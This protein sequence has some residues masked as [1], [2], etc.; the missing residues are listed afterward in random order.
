MNSGFGLGSVFAATVLV[1][2][3][4]A[5]TTT[6][7]SLAARQSHAMASAGGRVF[8][9]GGLGV[10]PLQSSQPV[11]RDVH[12]GTFGVGTAGWARDPSM[13]RTLRDHAAAGLTISGQSVFFVFGGISAAGVPTS[14]TTKHTGRTPDDIIT[15]FDP[16]P[17]FGHAMVRV[18]GQNGQP[19]WILMF[20]GFGS[21]RLND[22]W[23]FDPS[24]P[25]WT[26]LLPNAP[27]AGL[28][29][30]RFQHSMAYHETS[31]RIYVFGGN[32]GIA[33]AG[34]WELDPNA[35]PPAWSHIP[36]TGAAPSA[37]NSAAMAYFPVNNT[38]EVDSQIE[39]NMVLVL[40]TAK[41][42]LLGDGQAH[43]PN[44]HRRT[45]GCN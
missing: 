15:A 37:R 32:I 18:P 9:A 22:V 41:C 31:N 29:T 33:D 7:E 11:L 13:P 28:P 30:A 2:P 27:G 42:F 14:T 26:Q 10:N 21:S 16:G 5:Q 45:V 25:T 43:I 36:A 19:D 34:V 1:A 38:L 12:R 8:L 39:T 35:T 44:S 3:A 6:W 40:L 4:L 20:G 24:G 17:R 23:K